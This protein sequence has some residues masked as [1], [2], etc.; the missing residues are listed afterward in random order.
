MKVVQER[1]GH[2][3]T[4]L[5]ADPYIHVLPPVHA[6]AAELIAEPLLP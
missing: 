1:L 3:S 5:R 4:A 6:E 2:S